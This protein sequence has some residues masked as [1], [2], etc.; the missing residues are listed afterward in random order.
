ME[1]WDGGR[2]VQSNPERMAMFC[3]LTQLVVTQ[4]LAL[5]YLLR[6]SY[7]SEPFLYIRYNTHTHPLKYNSPKRKN[8]D[9][10][11]N[12]D[13]SYQVLLYLQAKRR[14][15]SNSFQSDSHLRHNGIFQYFTRL[16]LASMFKPLFIPYKLYF[17]HREPQ[18]S[19]WSTQVLLTYRF[20]NAKDHLIT[21]KNNNLISE[22]IYILLLFNALI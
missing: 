20:R 19:S 10:P 8:K 4:V 21:I 12:P 18:H 14:F 3:F 17:A 16:T 13:N 11:W 22:N 2:G 6:R 15:P 1:D 7:V 9:L 5:S